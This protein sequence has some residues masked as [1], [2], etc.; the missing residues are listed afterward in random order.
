MI[1]CHYC[2]AKLKTK[3][4]LLIHRK[5]IHREKVSICRHKDECWFIH[6]TPVVK[7]K[8]AVCNKEFPIKT[9]FMKHRKENAT[10]I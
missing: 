4:D 3:G 10:I 8:C 6:D 5:K 1:T 2:E 9:D 7:F